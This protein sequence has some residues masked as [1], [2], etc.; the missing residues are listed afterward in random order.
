MKSPPS[1][2]AGLDHDPIHVSNVDG[3]GKGP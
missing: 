1:A 2:R 3:M